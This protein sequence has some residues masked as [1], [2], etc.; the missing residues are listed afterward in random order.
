MKKVCILGSGAWGTVIG[1]LL[2]DKGN[3]VIVYG[4]VE[5]QVNEINST[6]TNKQFLGENFTFIDDDNNVYECKMV[7]KGKAKMKK[8]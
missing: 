4:V 2:A 8:K 1:S 3:E 7:Y 6:H 5:S